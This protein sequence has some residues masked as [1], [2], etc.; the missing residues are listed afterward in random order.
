MEEKT[1]FLEKF[2]YLFVILAV[3]LVGVIGG[4]WFNNQKVLQESSNQ[5]A[6]VAE[7]ITPTTE[8]DTQIAA[9]EQQSDSD[10]VN[11]IE[12]DIQATDLSNLDKEMANIEAEIASP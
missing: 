5:N 12:S 11:D 1:N 4:L 8:E 9:L 10:E 3:V 6:P 7:E 2:W